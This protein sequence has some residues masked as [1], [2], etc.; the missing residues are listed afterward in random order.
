MHEIIKTNY[1]VGRATYNSI[2]NFILD[3]KVQESEII[4]LNTYDFDD[5]VLDFREFYSSAMPS[6]IK[7]L[8]ITIREDRS[9]SKGRV[10]VLSKVEQTTTEQD[11]DKDERFNYWRLSRGGRLRI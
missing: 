7:I 4:L 2:R 9:I 8:G 11:E 1:V 6:D 10:T 5:L 3:N